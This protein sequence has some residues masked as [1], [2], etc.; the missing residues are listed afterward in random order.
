M[1]TGIEWTDMHNMIDYPCGK[2]PGLPPAGEPS[3]SE[4]PIPPSMVK[5]RE[6]YD[7]AYEFERWRQRGE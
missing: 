6:V 2:H 3:P 7:Y 5:P 1:K 4:P